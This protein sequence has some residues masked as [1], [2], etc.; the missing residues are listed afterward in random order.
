MQALL[1][2]GADAMAFNGAALLPLDVADPASPAWA[3]LE[4]ELRWRTCLQV[5]RFQLRI[6]HQQPQQA[7]A[8][9]L[10]AHAPMT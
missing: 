9:E 10:D 8:A 1:W 3:T 6:S 7:E 2:G 4:Q 5:R